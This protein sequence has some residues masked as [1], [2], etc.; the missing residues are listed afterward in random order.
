MTIR[1]TNELSSFQINEL[2][3]TLKSR[4]EKNRHRHKGLEWSKIQSKLASNLEKLWSLNAMEE[5][6]GEPDVIDYDTNSDTYMFCDC[7]QE[8]PKV[9]RSVCYDTEA[10]NARKENKP[11]HSAI[12]MADEMGV[13]VLT[14]EQYL[15]LQQLETFDTKTSVWIATPESIRLRGGAIFGDCR[16][17]RVFIYHNGADSYYAVRGFRA[18]LKV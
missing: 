12:G 17:G 9:R 16:Y 1:N 10:L 4:F 15:Q 18:V 14:E 2:L 7:S 13:E 11:Q 5:T 3:E 8:S 6:G